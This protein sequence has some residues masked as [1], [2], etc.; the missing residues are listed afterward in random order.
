MAEKRPSVMFSLGQF[1]GHVVRGVKTPATG[2]RVNVPRVEV[3]R[4]VSEGVRD[5]ASGP[6]VLR[7]T[8]I[9]EIELPNTPGGPARE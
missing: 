7:R 5:T 2:P 3:R 4:E 8:V 9:E 6:V 1:V